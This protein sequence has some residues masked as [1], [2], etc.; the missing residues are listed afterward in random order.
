MYNGLHAL[1][2]HTVNYIPV[3][4]VMHLCTHCACSHY[5]PIS[6]CVCMMTGALALV[7]LLCNCIYYSSLLRRKV[8]IDCIIINHPHVCSSYSCMSAHHFNSE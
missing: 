4:V 3:L 7:L 8:N 5:T 2:K 6:Q 1:C